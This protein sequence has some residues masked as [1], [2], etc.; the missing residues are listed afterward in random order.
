M[1]IIFLIKLHHAGI[2]W[3]FSPA[4]LGY[5]PARAEAEVKN[6]SRVEK[7]VESFFSS[8]CSKRVRSRA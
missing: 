2:T 8:F 1:L 3:S 7:K 4:A 6:S 5:L